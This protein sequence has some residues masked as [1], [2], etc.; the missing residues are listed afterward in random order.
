[1]GQRISKTRVS[2]L[3][4]GFIES[5]PCSCSSYRVKEKSAILSIICIANEESVFQVD[6][7]IIDDI[8]LFIFHIFGFNNP[9]DDEPND[10]KT[11]I[12]Y[13]DLANT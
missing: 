6:I 3:I 7:Y 8:H 11:M 4:L 13:C 2:T 1:M 12:E 10:N 9:S 5:C